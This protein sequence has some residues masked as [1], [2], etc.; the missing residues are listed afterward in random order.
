[1]AESFQSVWMALLLAS[2]TMM[3]LQPQQAECGGCFSKCVMEE[4]SEFEK[5][6]KEKCQEHLIKQKAPVESAK[7]RCD[8]FWKTF[9]SAFVNKH[10]RSVEPENYNDLVKAES[11]VIPKDKVLLYSG[12]GQF[13]NLVDKDDTYV[14]VWQTLYGIL[15]D[16]TW[17]GKENSKEVF[18]GNIPHNPSNMLWARVSA[19]LASAASGTVTV[20]LDGDLGY[21]PHS[22]FAKYEVPNLKAETV[23]RVLMVNPEGD[24]QNTCKHL[25]LTDL[26]KAM[27]SKRYDCRYIQ[28]E[29]L[30]KHDI[31][32]KDWWNVAKKG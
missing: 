30:G 12:T 19:A 21:M 10:Q 27:G 8:V 9:T 31:L 18:G 14:Y 4:M 16:R 26:Q 13:L 17:W 20:L 5:E 3:L 1:M 29:D 23:L 22:F 7:K 15:G 28:S 11:I 25:S 24:N 32:P 2:I 6:V